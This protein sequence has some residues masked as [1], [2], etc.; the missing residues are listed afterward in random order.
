MYFYLLIFIINFDFIHFLV[1]KDKLFF[2]IIF[3]IGSLVILIDTKLNYSSYMP[4][5][6]CLG[7]NF[8]VYTIY[9]WRPLIFNCCAFFG[10]YIYTIIRFGDCFVT[11]HSRIMLN[12]NCNESK[13]N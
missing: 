1:I 11:L 6:I 13:V 4:V 2:L 7:S 12:I 10:N 8:C 9:I 5:S 3:F